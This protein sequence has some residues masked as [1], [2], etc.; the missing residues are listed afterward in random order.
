MFIFEKVEL[1]LEMNENSDEN[2]DE[3][4]GLGEFYAPV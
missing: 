3:R 4:L 2:N 1:R